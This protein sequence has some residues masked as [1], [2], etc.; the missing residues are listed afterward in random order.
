[1]ELLQHHYPSYWFSAHLHCKFAAIVPEEAGSRI[2]KFLALDKCLPKRKFLQV[3]EIKHDESLPLILCYDL[4]WL[5]ILFLTNHLLS[6]KQG[7]HYMPGPA[8]NGRWIYTP[9]EEEKE[10]V[11]KKF[12]RSM[13]IPE[14]FRTTAEAYKPDCPNT[15]TKKS[16]KLQINPQTTEFCDT[17]GIDDP[18]VLLQ[19]VGGCY[20]ESK[21]N[22][23]E[24]GGID[25][26][27]IKPDY[28]D[29]SYTS[30]ENSS[31]NIALSENEDSHTVT[32]FED[33]SFSQPPSNNSSLPAV[34]EE[35]A[36]AN[37][38]KDDESAI[39]IAGELPKNVKSFFCSY[40]LMKLITPIS[41]LQTK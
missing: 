15:Q 3:V 12:N 29:L 33:L 1:M 39:P 21:A 7:I 10:N 23:D 32:D 35:S 16:L 11:L 28:S 5:T 6:V 20:T 36:N 30:L 4:E 8:G 34:R 38:Q 40:T 9:S 41:I 14:N 27:S 26:P 17:L 37:P 31:E 25:T 22:D 2:T 19:M 24:S 13:K 18:A